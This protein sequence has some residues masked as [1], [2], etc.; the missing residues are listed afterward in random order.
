MHIHRLEKIWLA[1]G[2]SML[3]VFLLVVGIAA[4]GMG[5]QT[6]EGHQHTMAPEQLISTPPFDQP[7][8]EQVD[9]HTY[10]IYAVASA[11]FFEPGDVEIPR[12]S[13]VTFYLTASDVVHGYQITGTTVN[14]MAV[15]GEINRTTYTFDQP[16]EYLILCNEYCG[17]GHEFM[18]TTIV[19]K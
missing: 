8:V 1:F 14:L 13:T 17:T 10:N 4:F 16:G 2:I 3:A 15:P 7:G 18:S 19:V 9:E 5:L 12:G 6:P 11:F